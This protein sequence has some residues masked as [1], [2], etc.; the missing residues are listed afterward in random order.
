MFFGILLFVAE[1]KLR[2]P[3]DERVQA[4]AEA[5]PGANCGGCGFAGCDQFA[6]ALADGEAKPSGCPVCNDAALQALGGILGVAVGQ[7]V[8][9][10]AH[11]ACRGGQEQ[12][13]P[14]FTYQGLQNCAAAA[15]QGGGPKA[16]RHGCLGMGSCVDACPFGAISHGQ[17]GIP[18]ISADLCVGCGRCVATCPRTL[19][20]LLPKGQPVRLFCNAPGRKSADRKAC[21]AGCL[22]CGLCAKICPN[23]AIQATDRFPTVD[24]ALCTGCGLCVEKCPAKVLG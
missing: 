2:V 22:S 11:I 1:K 20:S 21:S 5:L 18:V 4:L 19:I 7:A 9:L 8:P 14:R 12:S 6:K 15:A 23:G 16:C 3:V 17:N 13:P 10:A 24:A